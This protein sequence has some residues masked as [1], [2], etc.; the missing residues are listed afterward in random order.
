MPVLVAV[1]HVRPAMVAEVPAGAFNAVMEAAALNVIPCV[2]RAVPV[3]TI[4]GE[5]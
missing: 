3:V 1:I 4:L 5:S 2:G